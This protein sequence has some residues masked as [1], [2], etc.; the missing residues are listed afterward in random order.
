M[1]RKNKVLFLIT[2]AT[3]GGAQRYV[4]DLA[5]HL[6]NDRF[7]SVVAYGTPGK[8][9][10]DLAAAGIKTRHLPSLGRE[11]A[12]VSDIRSFFK[13]RRAIREIRP[14]VIHLNSSKAAA[15]GALAARLSGISKIVFTVHGWP[16]KERRSALLRFALYAASWITARLS[17]VIIVV[18]KED[19]MLGKRMGAIAARIRSIPLGIDTP[20]FLS[21]SEAAAALSITTSD[22]RIVTIAELTRNKGVHYAITATALLKKR[23]IDVS[24]FV[25]GAGEE[26]EALEKQAREEGIAERVHFL[27]FIPNAATYLRAFDVFLL[28]S[29]KEGAPYALLEAAQSGL[30]IIATEVADAARGIRIPAGDAHAIAEAIIKIQGMPGGSA[31]Q[32]STLRAMLDQTYEIYA[33]L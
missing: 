31:E 15:L 33:T 21:R 3:W 19:E 23:N 22:P 16:F 17:R 18:S 30:S 8:L 24:Y 6:P 12:L 5:T 29:I 27:G 32:C 11:I 25:M 28:P 1:N 9:T 13:I 26:R 20:I 4:Y 2:Q 14:D 7:E 10:D